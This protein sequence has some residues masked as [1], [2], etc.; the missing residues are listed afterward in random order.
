MPRPTLAYAPPPSSGVTPAA[1][2]S[3]VRPS[4]GYSRALYTIERRSFA[5]RV[6]PAPDRP[7]PL[8]APP[9]IA[10]LAPFEV[11]AQDLR[12]RSRHIAACPECAAREHPQCKTCNGA[13]VVEGW[14]EV[15]KEHRL[16]VVVSGAGPVLA[17]HP[18]VAEASDFSRDEWPN[19]LVHQAWFRV[20]P[21]NLCQPLRVQLDP[22]FERLVS[23]HVQ[24]FVG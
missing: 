24:T 14:L 9:D 23:L 19:R 12:A 6:A 22:R 17:R 16:Q 8:G 5:R 4:G 2:I 15:R 11:S 3:G 21:D 20:I 10:Q 18:A 13:R 1:P 7:G